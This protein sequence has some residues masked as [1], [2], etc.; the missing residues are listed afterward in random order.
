MAAAFA[1][2]A[3]VA[4]VTPPAVAVSTFRGAPVTA[5]RPLHAAVVVAAVAS[6]AGPSSSPLVMAQQLAPTKTSEAAA[7]FNKIFAAPSSQ[8][9]MVLVPTKST[10][11]PT[12]R[13]RVFL[14]NDNM[15]T[16]EYV[17]AVLEAVVPDLDRRQAKAIMEMAHNTGKACVGVWVGEHAECICGGLREAGL[18]SD[19][20]PE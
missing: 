17:T 12:R 13:Y 18:N 6:A 11:D 2:L 20:T 3:A 15:Q 16:K 7:T 4:R 10:F 9:G 14:F 19:M 8:T 5:P 1:P